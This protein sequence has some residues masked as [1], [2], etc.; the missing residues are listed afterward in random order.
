MWILWVDDFIGKSLLLFPI[1]FE[2]EWPWH[3]IL[4]SFQVLYPWT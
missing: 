1:A 3:T 4:L 2:N